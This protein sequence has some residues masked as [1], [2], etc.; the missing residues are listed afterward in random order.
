MV[1][2]FDTSA[3]D[4]S[5]EVI[6]CDD[7]SIDGTGSLLDLL[8]AEDPTLRVV[9]HARNQGKGAAIRSALALATGDYVLIQDA[10]LEYDVADY[11]PILNVL[12]QGAPVVYGSR[13][14]T[15]SRPLGMKVHHWL[16]NKVLTGTANALYGL[17]ITDEATCLKA[18]ETDVLKGLN[19]TCTAFEFCPE[20][21]AKLG[22][23]RIPI[24]EVPV[25]YEARTTDAGKKIRWHDGVQAFWVLVS[26]RFKAP[27]R[28]APPAKSVEAAPSAAPAEIP[29]VAAD[30]SH[31]PSP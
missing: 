24:V 8:A 16:A 19:L 7:G 15:R 30:V 2:A 3:W 23:S 6:V 22:L 12:T 27:P 18:F 14:L 13:F 25:Q 11:T 4:L 1:K 31:K 29:A 20:V 28:P 17:G 10:D 26:H 9:R 21:T 5:V